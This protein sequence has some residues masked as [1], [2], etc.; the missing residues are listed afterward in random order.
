[1]LRSLFILTVA[2]AGLALLFYGV[3]FPLTPADGLPDTQQMLIFGGLPLL[4]LI[5]AVGA[6]QSGLMRLL[7][8]IMLIAAIALLGYT[9]LS[10]LYLG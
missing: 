6:S 9:A 7:T 5:A 2:V 3:A 4:L 1:M 8:G 10:L